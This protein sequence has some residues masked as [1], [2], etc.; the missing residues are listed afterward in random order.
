MDLNAGHHEH[1]REIRYADKE[2][3]VKHAALCRLAP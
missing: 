2:D 3:P 1:D